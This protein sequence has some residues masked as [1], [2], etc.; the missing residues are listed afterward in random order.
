MSARRARRGIV[1]L[2]TDI[3]WAYAAQ[4]KAVLAHG[5]GP[6]RILD[7]THDVPAHAVEE[8]AFLFRAM[9]G[10]FPA[11]TIHLCV[12]DP[13]VGGRRAP[14]AVLCQDGS[15]LIGPDNGVLYPLA[16]QLGISK[17]VRLDA[18]R[19]RAKTRVGTAFDGRD[20]F[21]PAA[22]RVAEG[23][24]VATLGRPWR[25][26]PLRVPRPRSRGS[27]VVGKVLHVDPF[28]NLITNIPAGALPEGRT[29]CTVRL[30]RR[31][32]GPVA[33][34]TSYESMRRG[35]VG[36]L[37]SSFGLLEL[38]LREASAARALGAGAGDRVELS[39]SPGAR[40]PSAR[41]SRSSQR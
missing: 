39:W 28:G 16:V 8:G 33:V 2:T 40:F 12:V 7:L 14:V 15:V 4:M 32:L 10:G 30:G 27:S 11:G 31:R 13:G 6:H 21:A 25:L 5:L 29:T 36:L 37:G 34:A 35:A 41:R 20:L 17:V 38:S 26:A 24:A 3:G 18:S 9:A 22:V 19:V 1:T 23:A